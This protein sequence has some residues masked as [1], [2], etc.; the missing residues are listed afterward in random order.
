MPRLWRSPRGSGGA[1]REDHVP[2]PL[3][4]G[5][6]HRPGGLDGL[7]VDTA[8]PGQG[9]EVERE[10]HA[11]RDQGQ[12]GGLVD[13]HPDDEERDQPEVGQRAQ[14]L[15]RRVDGVLTDP[16]EAGGH[17]ER[18]TEG[19]TDGEPQG[20]ASYGDQGGRAER[21]VLHEVDRLLE[22]GRRG[23]EGG[24]VQDPH[25]AGELPQEH[26]RHGET[27]RRSRR[28]GFWRSVRSRRAPWSRVEHPRLQGPIGPERVL[29]M[30][31]MST[32]RKPP[33]PARTLDNGE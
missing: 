17:R 4:P 29:V 3:R 12:L 31:V 23:G 1:R 19:R 16:A 13:A 18:Q 25:A 6:V 5:E 28:R 11:H 30:G 8:D 33:S 2:Q 10:A 32:D 22:H 26:Q 15:H 20:H 14:H 9:V 24:G 21:A 27:H 7:A